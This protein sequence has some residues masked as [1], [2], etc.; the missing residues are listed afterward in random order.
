MTM[1]A[2]GPNPEPVERLIAELMRMPGIGRRSAERMAFHILKGTREEASRL[3]RA[4]TDVKDK[5]QHCSICFNLT[6]VDPCRLCTSSKRDASL[7]LIVEQPKDVIRIEQTGM[8][9]GVYHVLTG[10]ID[11]L[12]GVQPE[13]LTIPQLLERVEQPQ[14]NAQQMPIKEAI[15]GLNPTMEGDSTALFLAEELGRRGVQVSRLARGLPAGSQLDY[16]NAAVLADAIEGR[17]AMRRR[18]D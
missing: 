10:Q 9:S 5:V 14:H 3:S 6:D 1:A 18:E 13:D 4:I 16:A 17:Q 7:V 15:L 12:S 11:P 2:G 8:F